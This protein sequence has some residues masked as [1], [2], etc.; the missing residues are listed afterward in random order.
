MLD[1]ETEPLKKRY[2]KVISLQ[3]IK[4]N[5]LK[6]GTY[7]VPCGAGLFGVNSHF[8]LIQL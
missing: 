6:K 5:E 7:S 4:I 8:A 1:G 3:L 2:C